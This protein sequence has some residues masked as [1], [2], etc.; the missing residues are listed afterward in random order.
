MS[1]AP[2]RS[3]PHGDAASAAS[4]R[5][6]PPD[7]EISV[8]SRPWSDGHKDAKARAH[9]MR[10]YEETYG[11]IV[12][13]IVRITDRI[14]EEMD[15]GYI[16]DTYSPN[17]RIVDEFGVHY[18]VE[19][20]IEQTVQALHAFPDTRHYADDVIWA[21]DERRGFATSHRA[22]NVGHHLG[23]WT[24][25]PPTRR[26]VN[27]WVIAN[28][29]SRDNVIHE[30]WVLY[31]QCARLEQLGL[32]VP[33]AARAYGDAGFLTPLAQRELTEVERLGGGRAPERYPAPA[34]DA[35]FDVEHAVRALFHNTYNRRDLSAIDCWYASNVRWYAASNRVGYGRGDVRAMARA[36]LATFPDLGLQVD[37][38]YWMGNERDGFSV[39]VRW[40][41]MG[42]HRGRALYGPPTGRRAHIWGIS[43]LYFV[44]GRI[45]EDWM[46]FNEF[47]VL[48]QLLCDEPCDAS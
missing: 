33:A 3:G 47:D 45:V 10:G 28:C 26:P 36:L 46:L 32:D 4:P 13:Y 7:H 16:Y 31:N 14:W 5:F 44:G 8:R 29:V 24:W 27:M 48:A 23:S 15:V 1:V 18:G 39:S 42:T 35:P 17:C 20:V 12:D 6:M 9:P 40:T 11:D 30:E 37:E 34:P 2:E 19:P 22:I 21:G 25:G 38:V 43:Q 41:A